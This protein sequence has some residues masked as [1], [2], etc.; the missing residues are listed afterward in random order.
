MKIDVK[1][2]VIVEDIKDL[3]IEVKE[4]EK[5]QDG[6]DQENH[7]TNVTKS[8]IDCKCLLIF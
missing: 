2:A 8:I 6:D 1:S 4:I 7:F 5:I 3:S